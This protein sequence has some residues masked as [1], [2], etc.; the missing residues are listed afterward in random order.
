M[1]QLHKLTNILYPDIPNKREKDS[2]PL[3]N[4][5]IIIFFKKAGDIVIKNQ[6]ENFK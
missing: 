5:F 4:Y 3:F 2:I 6:K 1:E